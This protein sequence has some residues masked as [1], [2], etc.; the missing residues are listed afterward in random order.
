M[1]SRGSKGSRVILGQSR[2]TDTV[3]GTTPGREQ[4]S[5]GRVRWLKVSRLRPDDQ[6]FSL[7]PWLPLPSEFSQAMPPRDP[8][9]AASPCCYQV[10]QNIYSKQL[11][12]S[13]STTVDLGRTAKSAPW[14][15]NS[16]DWVVM[17]KSAASPPIPAPDFTNPKLNSSS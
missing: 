16:K 4:E 2:K 1:T 5:R 3:Y 14:N 6:I 11:S 17:D 10:L 15:R 9:P 12:L 7:Y 8:K 13:L